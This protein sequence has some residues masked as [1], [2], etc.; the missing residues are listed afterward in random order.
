MSQEPEYEYHMRRAVAP[1]DPAFRRIALGAG[2]VSALVIL[3]ALAWSG[4]RATGF[5]PPPVILPPPGP[6]R[7]APVNPGGLTVPEANE[8]IMSGQTL[9]SPPQLAAPPPGAAIAQLDQAAG[10]PAPPP[11]PL[12]PAPAQPAAGNVSVQLGAT[13]DE[14]GAEAL[15]AR[16]TAKFPDALAGRTPDIVPAI[17]KGESVWRVRV[18]GFADVASGEAFCASLKGAA[19]TVAAF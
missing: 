14:P 4:V 11:P 18:G 17:V 10:V 15:W 1:V 12:M 7:T 13:P 5:G 6:L 9:G 3:V 8:Q 2:G 19:C 16:L